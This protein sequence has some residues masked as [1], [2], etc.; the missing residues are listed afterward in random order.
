MLPNIA[1]TVINYWHGGWSFGL[2]LSFYPSFAATGLTRHVVFPLRT[3]SFCKV[4]YDILGDNAIYCSNSR[5]AERLIEVCHLQIGLSSI[6]GWY[7]TRPNICS[8]FVVCLV[9]LSTTT[10]LLGHEA[11][12][13]PISA[14]KAGQPFGVSVIC[15]RVPRQCFTFQAWP[16]MGLELR[17]PV[18]QHSPLQNGLQSSTNLYFMFFPYLYTENCVS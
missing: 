3:E 7:R 8:I 12:L 9:F 11:V 15:S 17:T 2:F 4:L 6:D 18:S 14:A 5:E 1:D 16:V 10:S 13:E